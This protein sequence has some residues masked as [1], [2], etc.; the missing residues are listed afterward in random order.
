MVVDLSG[1]TI[2]LEEAAEFLGVSTDIVMQAV[3]KNV[4]HCGVIA[5]NWTGVA[6]PSRDDIPRG[7]NGHEWRSGIQ[8]IYNRDNRDFLYSY[9]W[10][11]KPS[12]RRVRW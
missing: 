6:L 8:K 7:P 1:Y 5:K 10:R 9:W 4:L 12:N 2:R 3:I 11:S